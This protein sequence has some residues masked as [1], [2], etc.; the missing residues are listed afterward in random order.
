MRRP[1]ESR[2]TQATRQCPRRLCT[3]RPSPASSSADAD[4]DRKHAGADLRIA[5]PVR[6]VTVSKATNAPS[7]MTASAI[8][9]ALALPRVPARALRL[10]PKRH[11]FI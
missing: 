5:R 10:R 4:D 3:S 8:A 2:S 7:A 1:T 11:S 6:P 9:T